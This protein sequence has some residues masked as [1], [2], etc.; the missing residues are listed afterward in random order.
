MLPVDMILNYET[1]VSFRAGDVPE[2]ETNFEGKKTRADSTIIASAT[3]NVDDLEGEAVREVGVAYSFLTI[4][5]VP[6]QL[7][8]PWVANLFCSVMGDDGTCERVVLT[9]QSVA[10]LPREFSVTWVQERGL[11]GAFSSQLHSRVR[12]WLGT[13]RFSRGN[14]VCD[15]QRQR[16]I[17]RD[18][19]VLSE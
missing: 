3:G 9:R 5:G 7:V 10:M 6:E 13:Y 12:E 19:V 18:A 17:S 14:D 1:T 2:A 15:S 11:C 16:L 4:S 8:F